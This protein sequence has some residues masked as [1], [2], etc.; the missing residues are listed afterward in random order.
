M[1]YRLNVNIHK[2]CICTNFFILDVIHPILYDFGY[3][4]PAF[5]HS[6]TN[7]AI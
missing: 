1:I 2:L 7:Y 6:N 3:R 5:H 4:K